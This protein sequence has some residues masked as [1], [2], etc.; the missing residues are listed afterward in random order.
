MAFESDAGN[1][2]PGDTNGKYDVFVRD[3]ATGTTSRVSVSSSGAQAQ[4]AVC[5]SPGGARISASGRYVAFTTSAGNLVPGDPAGTDLFVHDRGAGTTTRPAVTNT[6][7]ELAAGPE[8]P[9]ISADGRYVA[10]QSE[11]ANAVAG[12]T[13]GRADV[14][15]RDRRA[16][17]TT[18]VSVSSSGEQA[19]DHSGYSQLSADGRSVVFSSAAWNLV[20]GDVDDEY[21][22]DVFLYRR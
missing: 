6:G 8:D 1:L 20:P 22:V 2:V 10:F 12:D 9:S 5:C 14:F 15:V 19:N 11:A 13:N 7:D 21:D 18:R 17:T 4:G 3:L 16:G